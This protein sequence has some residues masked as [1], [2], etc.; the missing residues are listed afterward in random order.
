MNLAV[1]LGFYQ[2]SS[3]KGWRVCFL[4]AQGFGCHEGESFWQGVLS[5]LLQVSLESTSYHLSVHRD[6][7]QVTAD[8]P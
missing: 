4:C 3:R 7:Q 2:T 1:T 8:V 5:S 6:A